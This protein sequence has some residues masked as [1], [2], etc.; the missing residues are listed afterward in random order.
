MLNTGVD[1][2]VCKMSEWILCCVILVN[3]LSIV[4]AELLAIL[5]VIKDKHVIFTG[6]ITNG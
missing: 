4:V 6:V 5:V 3:I 2:S 1:M